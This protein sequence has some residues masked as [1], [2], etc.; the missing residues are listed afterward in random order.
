M[1]TTDIPRGR[2]NTL[3][4]PRKEVNT[5]CQSELEGSS[6]IS[7]G[8]DYLYILAQVGETLQQEEH[9]EAQLRSSGEDFGLSL[10]HRKRTASEKD[11]NGSA[12]EI[13]HNT[14]RA[15]DHK[16][17]KGWSQEAFPEILLKRDNEAETLDIVQTAKDTAHAFSRNGSKAASIGSR[18]VKGGNSAAGLWRLAK[19]SSQPTAS[20][21]KPSTETQE[22]GSHE[23]SVWK[24]NGSVSGERFSGAEPNSGPGTPLC[25]SDE[26]CDGYSAE[27][28]ENRE[29]HPTGRSKKNPFQGGAFKNDTDIEQAQE[30]TDDE[31]GMAVQPSPSSSAHQAEGAKASDSANEK[32]LRR[33]AAN[34]E[35]ARQ[36]IRRKREQFDGMVR[37]ETMLKEENEGLLH[38][39]EEARMEVESL[40]NIVASLKA[41]MS[42]FDEGLPAL[43]PPD[44]KKRRL[45]GPQHPPAVGGFGFPPEMPHLGQPRPRLLGSIPMA[46]LPS[47]WPKL[48]PSPM[49]MGPPIADAGGPPWPSMP[50]ASAA[51]H[52][53]P[54]M[55]P[56]PGMPGCAMFPPPGESSSHPC[57]PGMPFLPP[58]WMHPGGSFFGPDA[59]RGGPP[60]GAFSF[61]PPHELLRE[62]YATSA[63]SSLPPGVRDLRPSRKERDVT[64]PC[65]GRVPEMKGRMKGSPC[66]GAEAEDVR[67]GLRMPYMPP[68][69]M[70]REYL[71]A[72]AGPNLR[73]P[74][75]EN[76]PPGELARLQ[77]EFGM[78]PPFAPGYFPHAPHHSGGRTDR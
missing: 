21:K 48:L 7:N 52:D 25:T 24:T 34:R 68:P 37:K 2:R 58:P 62:W 30:S 74:T 53:A 65:T 36:T 67:D 47:G 64:P 32:R 42:A 45:K 55:M 39:V 59:A 22:N 12:I 33:I 51:Q 57:L 63:A 28:P 46:S 8:A 60:G 20:S 69:E 5:V 43:P 15:L 40:N 19:I 35:A 11:H 26:N 54:M 50:V 31:E 66:W 27:H 9:E 78:R 72:M 4:K 70:M 56:P 44:P 75:P 3:R 18:K 49:A 73:P 38:Q 41:S 29:K 71:A 17:L 6:A 23:Y 61:M 13:L 76:L 77:M 16:K 10:Q 1:M 14:A